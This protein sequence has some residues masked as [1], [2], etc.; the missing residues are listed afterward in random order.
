VPQFTSEPE[1]LGEFTITNMLNQPSDIALQVHHTDSTHGQGDSNMGNY[2][3]QIRLV[4][5]GQE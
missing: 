4:N 2:K 1:Q 5:G 3:E